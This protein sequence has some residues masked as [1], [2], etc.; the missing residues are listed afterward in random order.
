M[1]PQSVHL[2]SQRSKDKPDIFL[3]AVHIHLRPIHQM[4]QQ[5]YPVELINAPYVV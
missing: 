4:L 3:S 5:M 1:V 2:T